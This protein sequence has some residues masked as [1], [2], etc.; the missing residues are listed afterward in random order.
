V[1]FGSTGSDVY[2]RTGNGIPRPL[3]FKNRLR[4]ITGFDA[5][6]FKKFT[7]ALFIPAREWSA[8]QILSVFHDFGDPKDGPGARVVVRDGHVLYTEDP[9][10]FFSGDRRR[11]KS[12]LKWGDQ[13]ERIAARDFLRQLSL[14]SAAEIAAQGCAEADFRYSYPTA[15]SDGDIANLDAMWDRIV[16]ALGDQTGI[17]FHLN[18]TYLDPVSGEQ[19]D[20]DNR[21]AITAT[22]F[23]C[24]FTGN[25]ERMDI[26]GGA[27]T[28]DIGGGTTD[29]AIWRKGELVSHSSVL[30]AGRDIFLNPLAK[31]PSI[32]SEIDPRVPVK[33][34]LN[35]TEQDSAFNA[36]LDA[37]ISK[38]GEE[39]IRGL[40]DQPD[41]NVRKFLEI[42]EAGLCGIGYYAG[43]LMRRVR[44]AGVYKP[45]RRIL[46]FA[47]G[48]GSKIFRWCALGK[49]SE[50]SEI[51]TRF[52]NAFLTGADLKKSDG[53]AQAVPIP[54]IIIQLSEKPKS[55]VA[56]GL[57]CQDTPL[58]IKEDFATSLAGE[59]FVIGDDEEAGKRDWDSTPSAEDIR[60]RIVQVQRTFPQFRQ[61]LDSI[62]ELPDEESAKDLF[63]KLGSEVDRRLSKLAVD[64]AAVKLKDRKKKR[65]E[66][67]LRNEPIFILALKAYLEIRT[68]EWA[69]RA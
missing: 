52:A 44:N 1:D 15:F 65:D 20:A 49:L 57:V 24:D 32:L 66:S 58:K 7:R 25:G 39:L 51:H 60:K 45:G 53:G 40:A 59:A 56:Y 31:R 33:E 36:H 23:F 69:G 43:L 41:D 37:I 10:E 67:L 17:A 62:D 26:A 5:T 64:A 42:L 46:I 4:Q 6:Q 28:L 30:F 13:R 9:S 3:V 35:T 55:E 14:Q 2:Q 22:K 11:V 54:K 63:D 29:M 34:L 16:A 47:G 21:E 48:N 38:H 27:V 50:R 68:K 8:D 18:P 19:T 61:F 12:N